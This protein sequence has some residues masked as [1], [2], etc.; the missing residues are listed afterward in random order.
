MS[1]VSITD[2]AAGEEPD[3]P[4]NE[5]MMG[6]LN[7]EVETTSVNRPVIYDFSSK[8]LT[9][10]PSSDDVTGTYRYS[11]TAY[12]GGTLVHTFADLHFEVHEALTEE[13]YKLIMVNS[14]ID[15]LEFCEIS[16]LMFGFEHCGM[17]GTPFFEIEV[18]VV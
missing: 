2:T 1:L 10:S 4:D 7:D 12:V 5:G 17:S 16:K 3:Q 8:T 14:N 9:F 15:K 11:F 18:K 6:G 13:D